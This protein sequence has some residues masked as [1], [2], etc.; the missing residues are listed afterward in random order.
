MDH[1]VSSKARFLAQLGAGQLQRIDIG[2]LLPG[3]LRQF[4]V[5]AFHRIAVLFDEMDHAV[6]DGCNNCEVRLFDDTVNS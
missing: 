2:P 6:V 1:G 4:P 5:T 3:A